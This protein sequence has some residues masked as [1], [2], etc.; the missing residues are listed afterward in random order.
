MP[1]DVTELLLEWN[2]G[3]KAAL[4][5]LIPI[6]SE[7]LHKLAAIYMRDEGSN[8]TL[9]PTA[10]VNEVYLKLI[11]RQRVDWQ[12][13]SHFFGFAATTMRR[14]LVDRARARRAD[15]RG[16][17]LARV[18]L[19]DAAKLTTGPDIDL[20]DLDRALGHLETLDPRLVQVVELRFFAGLSIQEA[21]EVLDIGVATV[22]RDWRTAKA[23]LL[24]RLEGEAGPVDG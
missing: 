21:A 15:K 5:R 6:V 24:S 8:K 20:L 1:Q 11:D 7:E 22:N 12:N 14:I 23:F 18:T 10:L 13:R 4:D 16:G 17:D 3:N 2:A 9:Q 19:E